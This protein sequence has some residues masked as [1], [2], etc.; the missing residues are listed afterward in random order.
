MRSITILFY[1]FKRGILNIFLTV[2]D[3]IFLKSISTSEQQHKPEILIIKI[4]AIGDFL[5]WLSVAKAYREIFPSTNF[6]LTLVCNPSCETLA[7]QNLTFDKILPLNRKKY[8]LKLTYR[9]LIFKTLDKLKYE[10]II[11]HAPSREYAS[12]DLLV[13]KLNAK[14]KIGFASD[15]AIDSKFWISKSKQFY[16][17][18]FES[19]SVSEHINNHHF[20]QFLGVKKHLISIEKLV[21]ETKND[22]QLPQNYVVFFIGARIGIRKWDINNFIKLTELFLDETQYNIILCGGNEDIKDAEI[23]Q[24]FFEYNLRIIDFVGK[25]T[26]NELCEVIKNAKLLIG[27]ETSGIHFAASLETKSVC[28]LGGGHFNRFVPYPNEIDSDFKPFPMYEKMDC[29]HCDWR[30]K[31]QLTNLKSAPCIENISVH[32]VF[33]AAQNLLK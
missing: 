17:I 6:S 32:K 12:G 24:N 31:Y 23:L 15:F 13:K 27:N 16:N 18:V 11:Y 9:L 2:F 5:V 19:K 21:F 7:K 26:I 33:L 30:C 8:M 1:H 22:L 4:D 28:I 29:F 25:T 10:K 14:Q 3:A 20:M